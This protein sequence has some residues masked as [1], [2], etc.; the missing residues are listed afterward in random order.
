MTFAPPQIFVQSHSDEMASFLNAVQRQENLSAL[1]L[2]HPPLYLE[3]L[4]NMSHIVIWAGCEEQ[5]SQK[6]LKSIVKDMSFKN[7]H[8]HLVVTINGQQPNSA[9]SE[10]YKVRSWS[11]SKKRINRGRRR[12]RREVT[13]CIKWCQILGHT[14]LKLNLFL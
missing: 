11:A 1:P 14:R 8:G 13:N 3:T 7:K 9:G 6:K 12:R 10:S 4:S 2:F 5:I